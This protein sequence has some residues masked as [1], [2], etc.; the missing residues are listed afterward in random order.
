MTGRSPAISIVYLT[1]RDDP[2]FE[3]FAD[4][5]ARQLGSDDPEVI[6]VDTAPSFERSE[7]YAAATRGRFAFRYVAAKP[8]PYV[9][10]HRVTAADDLGAVASARNTGIVYASAPYVVFI[11]DLS[12]PMPG[13]WD[14]VRA[15]AA[16]GY[17]VGGAYQKHRDMI[18]ADGCLLQSHS[19]QGGIDSRW[20]HGRDDTGVPIAGSRL[21]GCSF[22]APR[23][24]LVA[25]NGCDELCDPPGGE[26]YNLG[27][28]L[29]WAGASIVYDRRM[30][31]IE[32]EER[33]HIGRVFRRIDP[34]VSASAYERCLLRFGLTRRHVTG[35]HDSTH[36][37]LD[38]LYGVGSTQTLGNPYLL[39]TLTPDA[40]SS[41]PARFPKTYWFDGRPL[42]DL[43]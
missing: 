17:V 40:F 19:H 4:S 5:L 9:G 37:I 2:C 11:D 16:G 25:V 7:T 30:L 22:G 33:H 27:I 28:R 12:L 14:A 21:Y 41:L 20:S 43:A 26:D 42:C 29:E 3:W 38:L 32:S 6:L 13:W 36:M 18:V 15:A 1:C 24:A 23:E 31:T 39:A 35:R 34:V 10:P 8:S